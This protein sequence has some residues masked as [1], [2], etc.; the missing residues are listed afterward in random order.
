MRP[1]FRLGAHRVQ[2][3][4]ARG[5]GIQSYAAFAQWGIIAIM[6]RIGIEVWKS[7]DIDKVDPHREAANETRLQS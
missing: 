2:S 1:R 6:K 7:F 4:I 3:D 5:P